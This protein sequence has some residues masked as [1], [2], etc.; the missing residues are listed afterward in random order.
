MEKGFKVLAMANSEQR[1]RGLPGATEFLQGL[2][3]FVPLT[4]GKDLSQVMN[5]TGKP[6]M[7]RGSP[8]SFLTLTGNIYTV[9]IYQVKNHHCIH[10]RCEDTVDPG[11]PIL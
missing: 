1:E 6:F 7:N 9:S 11:E 10:G 4:Q 2:G 5:H 8:C 3:F